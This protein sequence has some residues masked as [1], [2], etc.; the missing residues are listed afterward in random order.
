M[1]LTSLWN[2]PAPTS[3]VL[4]P[5]KSD[6]DVDE[7]SFRTGGGGAI[8]GNRGGRHGC[9]A[10]GFPGLDVG[11]MRLRS[12]AGGVEILAPAKLN[13]FL[14]VLG[15]RPDGYHEIETVM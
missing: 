13:L 1:R 2:S 15:R 5:T 12:T 11:L 6:F 8:L 3:S 7:D 9:S 14:E 10:V 4:V